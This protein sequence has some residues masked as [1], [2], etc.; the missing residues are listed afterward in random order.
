MRMRSVLLSTFLLPT[1]AIATPAAAQL[2]IPVNV[3]AI[4]APTPARCIEPVY[5]ES[6]CFPANAAYCAPYVEAESKRQ[7]EASPIAEETRLTPGNAG[8]K[9]LCATSGECKSTAP[10]KSTPTKALPY[11]DGDVKG[12]PESYAANIYKVRYGI[13]TTNASGLV[14]GSTAPPVSAA[15]GLPA[16][17]WSEW[18]SRGGELGSRPAIASSVAGRH[19]VFY[20]DPAGRMKHRMVIDDLWMP[21]RDLGG[22]FQGDPAVVS[23]GPNRIDLF[24]RGVDNALWHRSW[25]GTQ[26]S[27]WTNRGGLLTA[28]PAATSS[29]PNRIDVV[30]RGPDNTLHHKSFDGV[31]SPNWVGLGGNA[32]TA[33]AIVSMEPGRIDVVIPGPRQNLWRKTFRDGVWLPEWED[34]GG[35]TDT[36]P[37]LSS[38]A[39]GVLDVFYRGKDGALKHK[40]HDGTLSVEV[41]L[42]GALTGGP[43]AVSVTGNPRVDVVMRGTDGGVWTKAVTGTFESVL[44]PQDPRPFWEA[45]GNR[46]E[47]CEEYTYEKYYSYSRFE[48][49]VAE[50]QYRMGVGHDWRKIFEALANATVGNYSGGQIQRRSGHAMETIGTKDPWPLTR[51]PFYDTNLPDGAAVATKPYNAY[52]VLKSGGAQ[53]YIPLDTDIGERLRGN[54]FIAWTWPMH[55]DW[56][57]RFLSELSDDEFDRR[58]ALKANYPVDLLSASTAY[59]QVVHCFYKH[60][61]S[62]KDEL[63]DSDAVHWIDGVGRSQPGPG[64]AAY[65]ERT[66]WELFGAMAKVHDDLAQGKALGCIDGG[67]NPTACDWS[68]REFI[69]RVMHDVRNMEEAAYD[70]CVKFTG[71]DFRGPGSFPNYVKSEYANP[72][73]TM[74]T[75]I[76]KVPDVGNDPTKDSVNLDLAMMNFETYVNDMG[77]EQDPETKAFQ[78]K[79]SV[80]DKTTVGG[81]YF[82]IDM[83]YGVSWKLDNFNKESALPGTTNANWCTAEI[84]AAA[85]A[86]VTATIAGKS[87]PVLELDLSAESENKNLRGNATFRLFDQEIYNEHG[88]L[89][90]NIPF[91][92]SDS[93]SFDGPS[94]VVL[95]LGVP[96]K[97]AVGAAGS[98][99]MSGSFRPLDEIKRCDGTEARKEIS[100]GLYAEITPYASLD[101]FAT[102]SVDLGFAEAGIKGEVSVVRLSVPFKATLEAKPTLEANST[103]VTGNLVATTD[104][105]LDFGTLDG[106]VSAFIESFFYSTEKTLVSWRGL[107]FK[108]NVFHRELTLPLFEASIISRLGGGG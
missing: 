66:R 68:P 93:K 41:N 94:G 70:R 89:E 96:V 107:H 84:H 58:A 46:V 77:L 106:R 29:G 108:T 18:K 42:G 36:G 72:T 7:Y 105:D 102:A 54:R 5:Q 67:P 17:A 12:A 15:K 95:V 91:G 76:I 92:D 33:P 16:G 82:G 50:K 8:K 71:N 22:P 59:N 53:E 20:L 38:P 24:A 31:W 100:I 14:P 97:L 98:V 40:R 39:P 99:G 3:D 60:L 19:D 62:G 37:A 88:T 74:H 2:V 1:L 21:A 32:T 56:G 64:E 13:P 87:W 83:S 79:Q 52:D 103:T 25:D 51:N 101:G 10:N 57:M 55:K 47:S 30:V 69:Q 85:K 78:I 80:G 65:A 104:L 45:N 34:F 44:P 23:R 26:W 63:C 49:L 35:L 9:S 27:E 48:D 43:S 4:C 11:D 86:G 6:G 90:A 81:E 28:S 61:A 75:T 73:S